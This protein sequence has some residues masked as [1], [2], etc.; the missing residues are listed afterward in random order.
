MEQLGNIVESGK[1][2]PMGMEKHGY[3]GVE[4]RGLDPPI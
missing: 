4:G 1:E 3:S 2:A